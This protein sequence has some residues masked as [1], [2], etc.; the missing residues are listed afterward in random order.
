MATTG[1]ALSPREKIVT[2]YVDANG[3]YLRVE[4]DPFRIY[5]SRHEEVVWQTSPAGFPFSV[6][7]K[8]GPFNYQDFSGSD[9][10][11]GEARRDVI[12]PQ[13]GAYYK[14]TV[15]AG[16]NSEDPGGVVNG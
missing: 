13:N 14:Y 11:S 3:N 2:I 1:P 16:N 12:P 8:N 5:K 10:Y 7:F 9:P 15:T 6:V 4:P